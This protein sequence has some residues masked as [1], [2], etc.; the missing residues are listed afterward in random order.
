MLLKLFSP[1]E[2]PQRR[3]SYSR[4][5]R[6][7]EWLLRRLLR[8]YRRSAVCDT[9]QLGEVTVVHNVR[10]YW[11]EQ[12]LQRFRIDTAPHFEKQGPPFEYKR[13]RRN[14]ALFSWN[15]TL[16]V[17]CNGK[18]YSIKRFKSFAVETDMPGQLKISNWKDFILRSDFMAKASV[19]PPK[20]QESVKTEP[21]ASSP[22]GQDGAKKQKIN[23]KDTIPEQEP[24]PQPKVTKHKGFE[25]NELF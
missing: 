20:E 17:F 9:I 2:L 25:E 22:K 5:V 7:Y 16:S 11:F 1:R 21:T 23:I 18:S 19:H 12:E 4:Y 10:D 8:V 14:S 6:F 24:R 15:E 13:K 3:T